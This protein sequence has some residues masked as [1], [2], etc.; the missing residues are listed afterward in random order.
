MAVMSDGTICVLV[1]TA[2][3][4]PYLNGQDTV[5]D[6]NIV[7]LDSKGRQQ[8]Y[9]S[10]LEAFERSAPGKQWLIDH[11]PADE[12]DIF[13]TNSVEVLTRDGRLQLLLS[14]RSISAI[15]VLDVA[16]GKIVSVL[17]GRW[18]KQHEAQLV[19][20]NLLLFDNLG[21]T[22]EEPG[23]SQSRVL[24]IDLDGLSVVWS[25]TETGFFSKGAGA[26]QR[27]PNDNTLITESERGRIIEVSPSGAI[28]WE[29]VNPAVM[30]E[31]PHLLPGILRAERI[32]DGVS[33]QWLTGG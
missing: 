28:V 8:S 24:E 6:D 25:F 10:L 30:P 13:H 31:Q 11:L 17:S 19:D 16:Y 32:P 7:L 18:H 4:R 20:G 1:R 3:T 23:L 14:I 27:L 2:V 12:P 26:Q 5:I 21:L 29:Y 33:T 22:K 15:A 9:I